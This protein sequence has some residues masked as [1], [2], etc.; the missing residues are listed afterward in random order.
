MMTSELLPFWPV[1]SSAPFGLMLNAVIS[2]SCPRSCSCLSVL[3]LVLSV[4]LVAAAQDEEEF[5]TRRVVL[6][7]W[8]QQPS[9][10]LNSY[11]RSRTSNMATTLLPTA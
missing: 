4:L 8:S 6:R 2:L 9:L 7:C 10:W 11:Q 1:A 5:H 3:L